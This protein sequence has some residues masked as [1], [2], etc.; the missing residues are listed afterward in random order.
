[1][2]APKKNT[3]GGIQWGVSE[4]SDQKRLLTAQVRDSW[5]CFVEDISFIVTNNTA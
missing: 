3:G 4:T 1:M 5:E 2:F